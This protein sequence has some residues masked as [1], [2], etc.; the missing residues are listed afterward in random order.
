V[1]AFGLELGITSRQTA[2]PPSDLVRALARLAPRTPTEVEAI[3]LILCYSLR[4]QIADKKAPMSEWRPQ[5]IPTPAGNHI[6]LV[7]EERHAERAPLATSSLPTL[8]SSIERVGVG[9]PGIGR[10]DFQVPSELLGR[11][12]SASM[13]PLPPPVRMA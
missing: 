4:G 13:L 3:A 6:P 12:Q 9:S 10:P 1:S 2:N 11:V 5:S 7:R 8:R